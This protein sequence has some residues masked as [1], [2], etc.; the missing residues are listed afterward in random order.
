MGINNQ[1]IFLHVNEKQNVYNTTYD[2]LRID[3]INRLNKIYKYQ[4]TIIDPI[5]VQK[6]ELI[7]MSYTIKEL[8][9]IL[10]YYGIKKTRLKKNEI[11][12]MLAIY[13]A[14]INNKHDVEERLRI[15][16]DD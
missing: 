15:W 5:Y 2:T 6:L 1:S 4:N 7:Y 12:K 10:D 3:N 13:E 8:H 9:L 14:D 16:G 11:I